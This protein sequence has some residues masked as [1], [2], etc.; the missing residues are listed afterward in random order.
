MMKAAIR[1]AP[2]PWNIA[3]CD[4]LIAELW[5][6]RKSMREGQTKLK[7]LLARLSPAQQ[8]RAINLAHY[9]AM[10]RFDLR[11][12][13]AAERDR[14]VVARSGRDTRLGER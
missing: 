3:A 8:P 2:D 5:T 14:R 7:P 12:A 13:G 9:L 4:A 11:R 10:R 6:L 1:Q